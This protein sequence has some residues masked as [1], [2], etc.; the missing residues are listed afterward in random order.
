[1]NTYEANLK[2]IPDE[3]KRLSQWVVWQY[4]EREKLNPQ[5]YPIGQTVPEWLQRQTQILGLPTPQQWMLMRPE[6]MIAS[7]LS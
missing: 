2:K 5:K 6:V 7:V 1:M 4:E 3:M